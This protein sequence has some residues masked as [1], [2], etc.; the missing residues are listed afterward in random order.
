MSMKRTAVVSALWAAGESWSLRG[1]SL[2]VFLI[3]ARLVEPS[4][5]GL[6]ALA[7][8]Y[9]TTVQALSD[10]GL[11]TALIQR[12]GLE[13]AHKDSAFWA[14]LAVG[15]ILGFVT[16]ALAGPA[17]AFYSEPR[18]APILRW[19]A[20]WPLLGSLSVVQQA[21]LRRA[22]RFRELA[23]RQ[24]AGA[25]AGGLVGI[26]M[27]YAGM[28]V[29]ALVA[30]QLVNQAVALVVLWSIAEWRPRF[31]FS[32]PHFRHLF[33]FG[34][35]VLAA[36]VVRAIGFQADR[37]VLGY[38]LGAT[39]LGYYSV[40]QRLLAIVT[41][42]VA[43]S[44]ERIV[45]P[46]FS[47]I[48]GERERVNRGLMTAQRILSLITIPAFVGLAASAPV[49]M[50][51][52]LGAKWQASVQSTQIL[53]AASLGYCL[54][55]FFGHVLTAL[56]RPG[57]RLGIVTAQALSQTVMSLIGVRF[58]VAG[59][60]VA[61]T[62]NQILFYG[63]ELLVLRSNAGFSL[64]AY[65]GEGLVPLAASI[66]MAAVVVL[67]GQAMA[68]QR[69]VFQLLAQVALGLA[70]YGAIILVFAR[71]RLTELLDIARGLR[72]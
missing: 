2:I 65:L 19:Y 51:V 8:V 10:Q 41:D 12:E 40:A 46:L 37:L 7:A 4:A 49:L 71:R 34:F 17:A 68:G 26:V 33:G 47:R 53:A 67:L 5:F 30:Q 31:A 20:L 23:L 9:V 11:A 21:L 60:A 39:E 36:N 72:P 48:Q 43:G 13:A 24:L 6:V 1:V 62:L 58:G 25:I 44:A 70:I 3:L 52:I 61:V 56:G 59:V 29:W 69:P 18:L 32:Y 15:V 50:P 57:L 27:A 54:S 14:N 66:A 22:L 35:N 28:G 63:V 45:V 42:F 38:F 16:L 55:F 64:R